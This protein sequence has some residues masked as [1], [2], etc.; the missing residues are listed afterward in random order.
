[1]TKAAYLACLRSSPHIDCNETY[2][3]H[4][5]ISSSVTALWQPYCFGT[6]LFDLRQETQWG[7]SLR[8]PLRKSF[9]VWWCTWQERKK[10]GQKENGDEIQ[11]FLF[12][13]V[14]EIVLCR[15][16]AQNTCKGSSL[17]STSLLHMILA[18]SL[19]LP[20]AEVHYNHIW[21]WRDMGGTVRALTYKREKYIK[22]GKNTLPFSKFIPLKGQENDPVFQF[23][24]GE[25]EG[26][27]SFYVPKVVQSAC[28]QAL[29]SLGK[30]PPACQAHA[31]TACLACFAQARWSVFL[32]QCLFVP[33]I[34]LRIR[35]SSFLIVHIIHPQENSLNQTSSPKPHLRNLLLISPLH[36]AQLG[37]RTRENS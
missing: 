36:H 19:S 10:K 37:I 3:S 35:T 14:K 25:S 31:L 20:P 4:P 34:T 22:W 29:F 1:M 8:R 24:D 7:W 18:P 33:P 6:I 23:A 12:E 13:M 21:F 16:S 32:F 26:W 17:R 11:F 15:C 9:T 30:S 28:G 5:L 2:L 27:R